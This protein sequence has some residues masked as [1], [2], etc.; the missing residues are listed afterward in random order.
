MESLAGVKT[1]HYDSGVTRHLVGVTEIAEVLGVSRQRADQISREHPDFPDPEV[2]LTSGRVWSRAA[3][4]E[5]IR[6]HPK[7]KSGRPSRNSG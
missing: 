2:T 6:L 1:L 4:D 7:R 3:I 5:W